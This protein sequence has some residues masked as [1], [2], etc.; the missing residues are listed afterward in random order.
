MLIKLPGPALGPV[1]TG[2]ILRFLRTFGHT[3]ENGADFYVSPLL[4]YDQNYTKGVDLCQAPDV[5]RPDLQYNKTVWNRLF[6]FDRQSSAAKRRVFRCI[7]R[8]P[9]YNE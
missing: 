1:T 4:S 8:Q 5:A 2:R 7:V 6:I 3:E 9:V